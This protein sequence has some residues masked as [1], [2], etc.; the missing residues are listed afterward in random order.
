VLLVTF[1]SVR[2]L[3]LALPQ[4]EE[5]PC[6]GTPAF[7][8]KGKLLARLREDGETLAL[9]VDPYERDGLL[10]QDPQVY[11]ITEHYRNYPMVLVRLPAV[12]PDELQELLE[13]AWTIRA[14]KRLVAEWRKGE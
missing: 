7:R 9:H 12:D 6:Y 8:V 1:D 2:E 5:G 3:A 10:A 13:K 11:Y 4:V 14:P